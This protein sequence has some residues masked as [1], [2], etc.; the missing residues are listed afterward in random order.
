MLKCETKELVELFTTQTYLETSKL[1][2][3]S[4]YSELSFLFDCN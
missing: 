3:R 4:N 1:K 2:F